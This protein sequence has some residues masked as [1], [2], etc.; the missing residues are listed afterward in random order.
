[1]IYCG[2]SNG[3]LYCRWTSN[4]TQA[5][6]ASVGSSY[7]TPAVAN[8]KVFVGSSSGPANI[9]CL[10]SS[11]GT[12]FW[13][14]N[15]GGQIH[16][17]PAVVDGYIY[18]GSTNGY[19]Y[20]LDED[21]FTDGNQG[22]TGEG[23]VG[24]G[25]GDVIWSYN[26]GGQLW[27]SPAIS[28]GRLY[29]G[30]TISNF[31]LYSFWASNGTYIW[32]TNLA[33]HLYSSP[34]VAD[35]KVVVNTDGGMFYC[36]NQY[37]GSVIWFYN[38]MGGTDFYSSPAIV[39]GRVFV[40]SGSGFFCFGMPDTVLPTIQSIHPVDG[41][42]NV[43]VNTNITIIFN[44]TMNPI[45]TEP[46]FSITPNVVGSF[47]WS[48]SQTMIFDPVN[49]LTG[50]TLFTVKI[51]SSATDYSANNL[52]GNGNG[53]ADIT[54]TLD[55]FSWNF[56]THE[57]IL[58]KIIIIGPARDAEN[59]TLN[60]DIFMTF[61][62]LMNQTSVEQAFTISPS[63]SGTFIWFD[64]N[65]TFQPD[66]LLMDET[67]Y[68]VKVNST[69]T[70]IVSNRLDGNKN[71]IF[72]GSPDDDYSWSFTTIEITPPKISSV[73]P[74][75]LAQD[76]LINVDVQ[77]IFNEP[78]N[79]TS[80]ELAFSISPAVLGYTIWSG[81]DTILTFSPETTFNG[82]TL[83]TVNITTTAM[84]R[85]GNQLDGNGNGIAEGSPTDDYSWS[86]TTAIIPDDEPPYVA[87]TVPQDDEI[88][89]NKS[90]V[91]IISFSEPMNQ[92]MT[93]SGFT[94][95]PYLD[96]IF[97]WDTDGQVLTFTPDEDLNYDTEYTVRL[98]GGTARDLAS[99]TLDGNNN[100][101]SEGSPGD[102][103]SWS[104]TTEPEPIPE[105]IYPYI[106]SV[107]PLDA[108]I[109]IP[110][111]TN[112]EIL[113]SKN[114]N[115]ASTQFAFSIS[116]AVTGTFDWDLTKMTYNPTA[117]LEY[118]TAYTVQITSD[119]TD[120]DT[121][122]LDGNNNSVTEGSPYDDYVWVFTTTRGSDS[123]RYNISISG[124]S[125]ISIKLEENKTYPI[126]IT[127]LGTLGDV[128]TP[129]LNAGVIDEYASLSDTDSRAI[130]AGNSWAINLNIAIPH[131]AI[132]GI[133]NITIEATSLNGRLT[134]VHNV[135]V[136]ILPL[137]KQDEPSSDDTDDDGLGSVVILGLILVVIIVVIIIIIMAIMLRKRKRVQPTA[138]RPPPGMGMPL[139]PPL[140]PAPPT[141]ADHYGAP[142]PVAV[143][144][145]PPM[146]YIEPPPGSV[147][148]PTQ[149][150]PQPYYSQQQPATAVPVLPPVSLPAQDVGWDDEE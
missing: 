60:T 93:E 97:D 146:E 122:P 58:P 48:D 67:V 1:M 49:P 85:V 41:S 84:D 6:S 35:G 108:A 33:N 137:D 10:Y 121:N 141:G 72:D 94:I 89:V 127:N 34:A 7:S 73:S 53:I 13:Q 66:A 57:D 80:V 64:K 46:A 28:N 104:F 55:D 111:D 126:T 101:I 106:V 131:D 11:N 92:V 110:I 51:S 144:V 100:T 82:S 95:I 16:S 37:N 32:D 36:L 40:N 114:M 98:M 132:T 142:P 83:Y 5:W 138:P 136:T 65:L 45:T 59:V 87:K 149:R 74:V 120:I 86:F 54:S 91:I 17:S 39:N 8:N 44:E 99:N 47:T 22:W 19:L 9:N 31:N 23:K 117:D 79:K 50:E 4:G 116:P 20:C 119:A 96:G 62:E 139:P 76:V 124:V 107:T 140:A 30:S 128:I 109:E 134:R 125:K 115:M 105:I 12:I 75:D 26:I 27:A 71:T 14:Y 77:T 56:T 21:G 102:D 123:V 25:Y 135:E 15:I 52:D 42:V 61:S 90:I 68:T 70:D 81:G 145:S 129:G 118:E 3:N 133:F 148:A 18:V 150:P 2:A 147:A 38:M 69:C 29:I 63:T 43:S 24:P 88:D 112:I 103:Y 113:F 143:P 130:G 78:M